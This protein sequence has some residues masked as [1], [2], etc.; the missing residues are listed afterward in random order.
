MMKALGKE[1]DE[2]QL[3]EM[4]LQADADGDGDVDFDE[5]LSLMT[6]VMICARRAACS[7]R[8][9]VGSGRLLASHIAHMD[10]EL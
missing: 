8:S 1:C 7:R 6:Q 4:M 10:S 2:D 9:T 5:F 3:A